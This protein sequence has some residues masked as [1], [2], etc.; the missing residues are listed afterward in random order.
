[1]TSLQNMS[2]LLQR[3]CTQTT[4]L[5]DC[6][7]KAIRRLDVGNLAGAQKSVATALESAKEIVKTL[8]IV[9][10]QLVDSL[11]LTTK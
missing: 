3:L 9:N 5:Q 4:C 1:M 2:I 7:Y 6:R 11:G 8:E 10:A